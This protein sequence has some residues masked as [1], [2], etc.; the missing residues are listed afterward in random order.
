MACSVPEPKADG[1][2]ASRLVYQS[3]PGCDC[4]APASHMVS[5]PL[6]YHPC[7][8]PTALKMPSAT[9]DSLPKWQRPQKTKENLPWADI[10]VLDLSK[11]DQPGGKHELAEEL[12]Q[13]VRTAAGGVSCVLTVF[14]NVNVV[15]C[16]V[17]ARHRLLQ[18]H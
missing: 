17:G 10:K 2:P 12:R 14:I 9:T 6:L 13:A 11:F 18:S 16:C 5:H 3:R 15:W 8:N 7:Q 1:G 4:R